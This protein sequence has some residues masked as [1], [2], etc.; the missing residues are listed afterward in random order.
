M[1]KWLPIID[2]DACTG[3]VACVDVCTPGSLEMRDGVAV[4]TNADSCASD[5]HCVEACPTDAI[6]MDWVAAD[7]DPAVG[8][9][10]AG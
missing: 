9:W 6:T 1:D 4:L 8:Q 3:C 10:Q 2:P 5:E 7:G